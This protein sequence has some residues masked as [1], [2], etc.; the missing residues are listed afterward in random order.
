M[1]GNANA[2]V[3]ALHKRA[4]SKRLSDPK[5]E[6]ARA[7]ARMAGIED[8]AEC[9]SFMSGESS[10]MA[11]RGSEVG[12]LAI[13]ADG[14]EA[15]IDVMV[16][17][18][19]GFGASNQ[20]ARFW[21]GDLLSHSEMGTPAANAFN[22][23]CGSMDSKGASGS[24]SIPG[25]LVSHDYAKTGLPLQMW[26]GTPSALERI[27]RRAFAVEDSAPRGKKLML[28]TMRK[29]MADGDDLQVLLDRAELR[30]H[31][32]SSSASVS[33]DGRQFVRIGM[34]ADAIELSGFL[35]LK[36]KGGD[37]GARA[38]DQLQTSVSPREMLR[39]LAEG[40]VG[41]V[42]MR[43]EPSA[44]SSEVEEL[45]LMGRK[46]RAEADAQGQWERM[47]ALAAK[48]SERLAH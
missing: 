44:G 47:G 29:A 6:L 43:E 30:D 8:L 35:R 12:M 38:S 40:R 20:T 19:S 26:L 4:M 33:K 18:C 36:R 1:M 7:V 22:A 5:D 15:E 9:C 24:H 23:I 13:G 11:E 21:A 14:K 3:G 42:V 27:A 48:K 2:A 37:S 25:H 16:K 39:A 31:V 32:K 41:G 10:E 17:T 28:I 46:A 45:S 34:S